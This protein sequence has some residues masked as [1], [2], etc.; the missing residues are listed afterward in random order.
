MSDKDRKP[1]GM[2]LPTV[3]KRLNGL[4]TEIGKV[5]SILKE[6]EPPSQSEGGHAELPI[7]RCKGKD[8]SFSTD[9]IEDYVPHVV[10]ERLE[11]ALSRLREERKPAAPPEEPPEPSKPRHTTIKEYLDCP[12]CYPK[13]EDAMLKHPK[14]KETLGKMQGEEKKKGGVDLP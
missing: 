8:C 14:F 13:F 5:Y 11:H 4:E 3:V 9:N 2:N 12:E 6:W 1:R 7:Y 10:E